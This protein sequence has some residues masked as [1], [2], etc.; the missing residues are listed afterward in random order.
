MR[1][2]ET[3]NKHI[4]K[5][6]HKEVDYLFCV[7]VDMVFRNPWG[8]ETLGDLGLPFT[9]AIL[10]YLAGNSLMNAGKFPLPLWQTMRGT[11]IM[12]GHSLGDEWPECMSLPGPATWPFW[13]TKLTALW[14]PGRRRAT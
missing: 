9:Q 11:S 7:D 3:I 14:Q 10:L 4:A 12:V 5:R 6:A 2:M 8:P 1:R 13:Q